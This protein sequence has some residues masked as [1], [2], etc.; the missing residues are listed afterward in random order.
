LTIRVLLVDDTDHVREMLAEMLR[1]DGFEI[2]GEASS[3]HDAIDLAR[4]N[5]PDVIV[6]DLKMPGMDGITAT[7]E[8]R[9]FA[10][11]TP[12]ILYTAYL[13]EQIE[14]RAEA[15]GVTACI[16]KIEG[17]DSLEREISTLCLDLFET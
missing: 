10:T 3:G 1:L 4:A 2:A 9:E 12:I 11:T 15:A 17:I 13:D 16:G 8:I 5:Q 7:S 14:Q 6:M